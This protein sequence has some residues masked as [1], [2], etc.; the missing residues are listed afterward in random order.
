MTWPGAWV[1]RAAEM[2]MHRLLRRPF[3][4]QRPQV[5]ST[6]G[7]GVSVVEQHACELSI[8]AVIPADKGTGVPVQVDFIV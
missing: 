7:P 5:A 8:D 3:V 2:Q 1:L 4:Y 6:Y